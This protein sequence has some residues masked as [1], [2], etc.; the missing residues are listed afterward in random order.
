M[1]K[2][3]KVWSHNRKH[4]K[5]IILRQDEDL[6]KKFVQEASIK[7]NIRGNKIVL[8]KDGTEVDEDDALKI[9]HD[10][11]YIF[12]ILEANQDW[13]QINHPLTVIK[14]ITETQESADNKQQSISE[15][16]EMQ[17]TEGATESG[18]TSKSTEELSDVRENFSMV[19]EIERDEIDEEIDKQVNEEIDEQVNKKTDEEKTKINQNRQNVDEAWN[20]F[21]FNWNACVISK[22]NDLKN[23]IK[24]KDVIKYFVHQSIY[25][26]R[27]ISTNIPEYAIR[28]VVQQFVEA[29]PNVFEDRNFQNEKIGNGCHTLCSKMI[30]RNH[31]LNRAKEGRNLSQELGVKCGTL[32]RL[33]MA[34]SGCKKWQPEMKLPYKIFEE[35]RSFLADWARN[36]FADEGVENRDPNKV[37][38]P[39]E[40]LICQKKKEKSEKEFVFTFAFQRFFLNNLQNPPNVEEIE[41]LWPILFNLEFYYWH[42]ELLMGHS[43][44]KVEEGLMKYHTKFSILA[45]KKI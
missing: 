5:S 40:K 41:D 8:E 27:D 19:R 7:F 38:E 23:N 33:R 43:I 45:T 6:I 37:R 14:E 4:R 20:N 32:A 24:T 34:Q 15:D 21:K 17:E 26:M 1:P 42:Y 13:E 11:G 30:N 28:I 29:Y 39:A 31:N 44:H 2:V 18:E 35:K 25:Q 9:F 22:I 16:L 36:P 3:F 12:L 10:E